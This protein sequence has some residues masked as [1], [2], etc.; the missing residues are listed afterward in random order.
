M[1]KIF[2]I[3]IFCLIGIVQ[4]S[5]AQRGCCS[6][7]GGVAGCDSNIG[8]QIC[9]DGTYSPSCVCPINNAANASPPPNSSINASNQPI[10]SQVNKFPS[11]STC[12][13]LEQCE[14]YAGQGNLEA[15]LLLGLAYQSGSGVTT[16]FSKAIYWYQQGI[17][18]P[19]FTKRAKDNQD[20]FKLQLALLYNS[21]Q[22]YDKA[23]ELLKPMAEG[24]EQ[25]SIE[26]LGKVYRY[27][28]KNYPEAFY[29][30]QKGAKL[31]NPVTQALLGEMYALGEGTLQDDIKA[32]A[33]TS[34]AIANGLPDN[35]ENIAINRRTNLMA[36]LNQA[37]IVDGTSTNAGLSLAEEFHEK[38]RFKPETDDNTILLYKS[39][40]NDN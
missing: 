32:Y 36:S 2:T 20:F 15:K 7:H 19:L 38:Y 4:T 18:D 8:R 3:T 12:N 33:W 25:Y 28:I 11:T 30:F 14:K 34:V 39:E 16:D 6:W 29:W 40:L 22:Q 9:R 21:A 10:L 23:I 13:S 17:Q 24:G 1:K 27:S 5:Q 35:M 26:L 31:G 37:N